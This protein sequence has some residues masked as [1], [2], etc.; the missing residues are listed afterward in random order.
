MMSDAKLDALSKEIQA[1]RSLMIK[2]DNLIQNL[3][4]EVKE[5]RRD[6][7]QFV[8]VSRFKTFIA[9]CLFATLSFGGVY[10]AFQ[11]K[12][13]RTQKVKNEVSLLRDNLGMAERKN[14]ELLIKAQTLSDKVRRL[15]EMYSAGERD[16]AL[17]MYQELAP[18]LQN[19]GYFVGFIQRVIEAPNEAHNEAQ[20]AS[21]KIEKPELLIQPTNDTPKKETPP[22]TTNA[23]PLR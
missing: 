15:Y 2:T 22:E 10:F 11:S 21:V 16:K 20:N 1:T 14:Q 13:S 8:S 19:E 12:A 5:S 23:K 7:H 4:H 3:H 6:S 9:Y 17:I 18:E